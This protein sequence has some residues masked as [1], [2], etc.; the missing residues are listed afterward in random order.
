[1]GRDG[2]E[3]EGCALI[4]RAVL[5]LFYAVLEHISVACNTLHL[6]YQASL[7]VG[8]KQSSELEAGLLDCPKIVGAAQALLARH[9]RREG[10]AAVLKD[11]EAPKTGTSKRVG[12]SVSVRNALA[13]SA[14]RVLVLQLR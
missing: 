4:M 10:G 6:R 1:M 13:V 5:A 2:L 12:V 7:G 8:A 3:W 14:L 11:G 9:G